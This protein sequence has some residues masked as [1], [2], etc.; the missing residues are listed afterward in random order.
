MSKP[1]KP[2]EFPY[3]HLDILKAKSEDMVLVPR[4]LLEQLDYFSW[5]EIQ[6]GPADNS[7][8]RMR[9]QLAD[10]LGW[11]TCDECDGTGEVATELRPRDCCIACYGVGKVK[12]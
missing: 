9:R 11:D 2:E 7:W 4:K 1:T 6:R 5:P 12:E 8:I 10:V 3:N